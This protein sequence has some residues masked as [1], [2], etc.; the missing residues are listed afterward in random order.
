MPCLHC[1]GMR[2]A[3]ASWCSI[4]CCSSPVAVRGIDA[5]TGASAPLPDCQ[6][7]HA[8]R[9]GNIFCPQAIGQGNGGG[10][11]I[12]Q[13][14][15]AA[16]CVY[17]GGGPDAVE[18][19]Y[20]A[21]VGNSPEGIAAALEGICNLPGQSQRSGCRLALDKG[22]VV[23]EEDVPSSLGI[24]DQ[25]AVSGLSIFPAGRNPCE[26]S[27]CWHGVS[28]SPARHELRRHQI[29]GWKQWSSG[30]RVLLRVDPMTSWLSRS[31]LPPR[32]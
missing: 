32:G 19:V 30:I 27:K 31:Y 2:M 11:A 29:V 21:L 9:H 28:P 20:L 16:L 25:I 5:V 18:D 15:Y 3:L 4:I 7:D 14:G 17:P 6:V 23:E 22:T 10:G 13:D 24:M 26:T 8:F 1:P 12:V